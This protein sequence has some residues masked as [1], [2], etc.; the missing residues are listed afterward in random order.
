MKQL[1]IP[2]QLITDNFSIS[3]KYIWGK[4]I[5]GFQ[6]MFAFKY[7]DL[8]KEGEKIS[9]ET[10]KEEKKN[11]FNSEILYPPIED[12]D[13]NWYT[14]KR[15]QSYEFEDDSTNG[16]FHFE[17]RIIQWMQSFVSHNKNLLIVHG[18][19]G[20]GKTTLLR[21]FFQKFLLSKKYETLTNNLF[22][23]RLSAPLLG[24]SLERMEEDLDHKIYLT[25]I[26]KFTSGEFNLLDPDTLVNMCLTDLPV[27]NRANDLDYFQVN[28]PPKST[29][30]QLKWFRETGLMR[31]GKHIKDVVSPWADFNRLAL[32]Y[33][34]KS[35]IKIIII[36][37]NLDQLTTEAQSHAWNI[38]RNKLDWIQHKKNIAYIIAFR[39]YLLENCRILS[40]LNAY[41]DKIEIYPLTPPKLFDILSKRK[42]HY[43]DPEYLN[44]TDRLNF[45]DREIIVEDINNFVSNFLTVFQETDINISIEKLSNFN[46]R[47]SFEIAK[48]I[49]KYPFYEANSVDEA[50][51][52][53]L[54]S[55]NK[56]S[57]KFVS[58]SRIVDSIVRNENKLCDVTTPIL[59]NLYSVNKSSHF[60]NTLNKLYTLYLLQE[61]RDLDEIKE[62]FLKLDHNKLIVHTTLKDFLEMGIITSHQGNDL[63]NHD[64]RELSTEDSTLSDIYVNFLFSEL[65]YLQAM[66]Y[67][68][69]MDKSILEK[70]E[71]PRFIGDDNSLFSNRILAAIALVEQFC[72]DEAKQIRIIEMPGNQ[73]ILDVFMDNNLG[74]LGKKLLKK[75][76]NQINYL[77]KI[78]TNMNWY[79]IENRLSDIIS[80]Y[81]PTK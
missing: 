78:K 70:F 69:Y 60:S 8:E 43:F 19:A 74:G 30:G 36:L 47:T 48:C 20:I 65:Y 10:E 66:A 62:I 59:D 76:Q 52:Y 17:E 14:A 45:F 81:Y 68:T 38:V 1:K 73:E 4:W 49:F 28:P 40:N 22:C 18:R 34:A 80:N 50:T 71:T 7:G 24:I 46:I 56:E 23:I 21:Y 27:E 41:K 6:N 13:W 53:T 29:V 32:N 42:L 51:K 61:N 64:I 75:V 37:D 77:S 58:F 15:R 33:L 9:D 16:D 57:P 67:R 2:K 25:L 39:S 3:D 72:K 35:G 55:V 79:Q 11:E 63:E 5:K 54:T 26:K 31:T 44:K 12:Y